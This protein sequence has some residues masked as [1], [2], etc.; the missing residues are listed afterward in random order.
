MPAL[1]FLLKVT[2]AIQGLL[3]FH[4]NFRFFSSYVKTVIDILMDI[5]L[6]LFIASGSMDILAILFLSIYDYG[7]LSIF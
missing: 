1:C 7:S 3:C 2:L 6:N 4:I 5:S